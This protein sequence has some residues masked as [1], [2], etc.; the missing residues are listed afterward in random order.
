MRIRVR[1]CSQAGRDLQAARAVHRKT[2]LKSRRV[3]IKRAIFAVVAL[4]AVPGLPWQASGREPSPA[5]RAGEHRLPFQARDGLIYIQARVNGSPRTLL[6]DTGAVLTIF[7]I[8]AVPTLVVDSAITINMAKGSVSASRLPVGLVLGDSHPARTTLRFSTERSGRRLQIHERRRR[9]RPRCSEPIQVR[10][11]R[12]QE[13]SNGSGG[14]LSLAANPIRDDVLL[15]QTP[16]SDPWAYFSV[17]RFTSQAPSIYFR[18]CL[19]KGG[20]I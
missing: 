2:L 9:C 19:P 10:N 1:D 18:L 6:I 11:F 8:K 7:T 14:P 5:I 12:F 16:N 3:M 20:K 15:A 13:L 17:C 4:L